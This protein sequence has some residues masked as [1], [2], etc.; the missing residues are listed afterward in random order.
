MN[1]IFL[2]IIVLFLLMTMIGG[3]RGLKSF[4][5]LFFNLI[6]LFIM[7]FFIGSKF[8]PIKV[9]V[10]VSVIITAVTLF[11][12]NGVNKKTI[13]SLISVTLVVLLT[14][15]AIYKIGTSSQIQGFGSEQAESIVALS[16]NVGVSFTKIVICEVLI[17]LLGAI[18]D[19]SIS[20][21]SSINELYINNPSSSRKELIK[22]GIEIGRDILGTMTN[23]L[24]FAFIS[25][26]MTLLIYF[27]E[28]NYSLSVILNGKI[29]CAEVFQILCS[30]IGI[31][32]VI[33][34]T[35]CIISCI[36][37][38]KL[39]KPISDNA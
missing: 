18:T 15:L 6:M 9:T 19:V 21:S 33:P 14:I 30:G 37:S 24:L 27:K 26:F 20:I 28:L 10:Y 16:V 12:I 1:V 3:G 29:F 2:L 38:F 32:L 34:V 31:I 35:S 22:S 25:E 5:I 39:N 17:G 23:T 8:D 7:M 4:I 36:L 11:F 13:S